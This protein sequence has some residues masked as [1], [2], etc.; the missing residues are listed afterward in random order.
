MQVTVRER[1][2]MVGISGIRGVVGEAL[3]PEIACRLGACLATQ[4]P[5]GPVV[6]GRDSRPSGEILLRAVAVGLAGAGRDV[7]DVGVFPTPTVQI[8]AREMRAA[9]AVVV[10]GS[11]NPEEWNALKF[12]GSDGTFLGESATEGLWEAYLGT[13]T[14][15]AP[16]DALGRIRRRKSIGDIHLRAIL[17]CPLVVPDQLRARPL[18]VAVDC[19]NGAGSRLAPALLKRLGC[20]VLRLHC[21]GDGQFAHPPEPIPENL[22][23][24]CGLVRE[25]GADA[26]FAV[27]PDADRLSLVDETGTAL[28]EEMTLPLAVLHAL[29]IREG[30]VVVNYSTS[31]MT[32][33]VCREHGVPML[34]AP[35]GEVNVVA[36]MRE[37]AAVVGGEG[38]GG[39][40]LPEVQYARDSLTAMSLIASLL[41]QTGKHLSTLRQELPRLFIVKRATSLPRDLWPQLREQLPRCIPE[42]TWRDHDGARAEWHGGWVHVRMSRTEPVVRAIAEG[43]DREVAAAKVAAVLRAVEN[44]VS[45]A[46]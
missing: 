9:G 10:T 35:V 42:A 3:T 44:L 12:V 19:N 5:P 18:R 14:H 25:A 27:D 22:A 28:G 45:G 41:V 23:E 6:V 24:L 15:G 31:S 30:P 17:D 38:N 7:V 2:L 11:H 21:R 39:V 29:S 1:G 8:A 34:R 37:A 13:E 26:G 46:P 16:W 32:E 33:H 40:I 36:E 4:L 20:R 43:P